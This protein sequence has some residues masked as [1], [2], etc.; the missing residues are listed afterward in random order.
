MKGDKNMLYFYRVELKNKDGN[1]I[2]TSDGVRESNKHL[3]TLTE[4]S[5]FR[6]Q[7]CE[8]IYHKLVNNCP[9]FAFED[10]EFT[11]SALNPL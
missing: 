1:I 10:I 6:T 9:G 8:C 3:K 5:E 4:Y 7:I 2:A 11:F